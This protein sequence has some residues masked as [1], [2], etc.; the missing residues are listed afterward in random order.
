[1]NPSSPFTQLTVE[2][3][4]AAPVDH[5]WKCWTDPAHVVGWNFASDD[6]HAPAAR[7]DLRIG[8]VFCYTM[9][10]KDGSMAFDFEGT[11]DLLEPKSLLGYQLGDGRAVRI[12][13]SEVDG[14]THVREVF[15]AEGE[16]TLELQQQGW[17]SILD[18]FKLH[19][20]RCKAGG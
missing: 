20:E 10:A 11:F 17:Q 5:V 9:A 3:H 6:W 14:G 8:G 7:N 2:V 12:Y 15:D 16:N 1:M 13:F 18:N 19:A 4:V